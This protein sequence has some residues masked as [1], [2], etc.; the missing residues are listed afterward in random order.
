MKSLD[1]SC[2]V[3]TGEVTYA[4]VLGHCGEGW[5]KFR[6]VWEG[7]VVVLSQG[8]ETRSSWGGDGQ[9]G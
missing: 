4:G 8:E 3:A 6:C 5:V 1:L 2:N 7:V 9:S